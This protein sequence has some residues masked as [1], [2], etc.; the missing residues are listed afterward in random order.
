[1][2]VEDESLNED[3]Y[4]VKMTILK[5]PIVRPE[6]LKVERFSKLIQDYEFGARNSSV[7]TRKNSASRRDGSYSSK[8]QK[9]IKKQITDS[10]DFETTLNS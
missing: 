7:K 3:P 1:M 4:R 5:Q 6:Y 10:T 9:S 2:K 8:R